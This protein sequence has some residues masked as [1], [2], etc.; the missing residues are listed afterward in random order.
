MAGARVTIPM[1]ELGTYRKFHVIGTG[2]NRVQAVAEASA[3]L[4]LTCGF[5]GQA[6]VSEPAGFN[7]LGDG[8][9]D[10][11]FSDAELILQNGSG[12]KVNIYLDNI[13]TSFGTGIDGQLDMTDPLIIAFAT[14]YRDGGGL[15]GYTP[16]SG[17][18]VK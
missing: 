4:A 9:P 8:N 3:K 2:P 14:A 17:H 18:Y 12:K 10:T 5:V 1:E 7:E 6:V 11:Q 16:F 15:G 13:S